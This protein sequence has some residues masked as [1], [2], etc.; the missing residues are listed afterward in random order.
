VWLRK[1]WE[2]NKLLHKQT[3]TCSKQ[4]SPSYKLVYGGAGNDHLFN[5]K[6]PDLGATQ[7]HSAQ[8]HITELA[9]CSLHLAQHPQLTQIRNINENIIHRATF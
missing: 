3:T 5:I 8:V 7:Y 4:S 2:V 6:S 1:W 9:R